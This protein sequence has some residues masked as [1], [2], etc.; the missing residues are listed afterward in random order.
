LVSSIAHEINNPLQAVQGCLMLA[1]REVEEGLIVTPDRAEA[2]LKDLDVAT[3]EVARI[4]R[5]VERLHDFYRPARPGVQPIEADAAIEAVLALVARQ[6]WYG[7]VTVVHDGASQPIQLKTNADQLKQVL[8]NL[9]LNSL[10]A[11][12]QGGTLSIS[13]HLD[14]LRRDDRIQPAVRIDLSDTGHGI[15]PEHLPRIFEPF[16]TTKE[17][18]S[19]LGLSISYELI[20]TLGGEMSVTSEVG[21]G[22][23][24]TIRL[25]LELEGSPL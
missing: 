12:P 6:L 9:T 15:S 1:Q 7:N 2:L 4:A 17:Q 14:T 20:K 16:F 18:G 21:T 19:G 13:A 10:D 24:F 3:T 5:L 23:T 22:T 11:M 25:P 8:L